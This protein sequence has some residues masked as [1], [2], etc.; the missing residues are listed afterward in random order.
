[1]ET[2]VAIPSA[3]PG[4]LEA[5]LSE[6]FGHCDLFT[7]VTLEEGH[8]KE[9]RVIPNQPHQQGGCLAP[10]QQLAGHGVQ[11]LVAGGLGPRPLLGFNQAGIEVYHSGVARTVKEAVQD[12]AAGRLFRFGQQHTCGGHG[13]HHSCGH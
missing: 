6:H 8:P 2:I 1:M 4:G 5:G 13:P 7:L 3:S 10:V 9:V 12:L 11:V